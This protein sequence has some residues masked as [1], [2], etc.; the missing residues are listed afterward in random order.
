MSLLDKVK[1]NHEDFINNRVE[2]LPMPKQLGRIS[3]WLPGF[4]K[5]DISAGDDCGGE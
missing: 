4:T 5:F 1:K 2:Y 3:E